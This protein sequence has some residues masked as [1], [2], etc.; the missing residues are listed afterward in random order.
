MFKS[1]VWNF[2][3]IIK[4]YENI[5]CYLYS[6]FSIS[7]LKVM[8]YWSPMGGSSVPMTWDFFLIN[9]DHTEPFKL[10]LKIYRYNTSKGITNMERVAARVTGIF[11]NI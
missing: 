2:F 1:S 7:M 9:L 5:F 6:C 11:P 10:T 4:Y 3:Q 8:A